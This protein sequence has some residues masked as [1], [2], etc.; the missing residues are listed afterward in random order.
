MTRIDGRR[1][2]DED[3][4][5]YE[6]ER[7]SYPLELV[8][9]II[10]YSGVD[11]ASRILEIGCGTGQA[12]RL[13]AQNGN[14]ILGL[15]PGP[16]L[17]DAARD[18]CRH[19][20]NVKIETV[21]FEDWQL[22]P[23]AFDL[24]ISATAFHWIKPEI[25]FPKCARAL[26]GDGSIGL[27]WNKHPGP[28]AAVFDEMNRHYQTHAPHMARSRAANE[29]DAFDQWISGYERTIVGTGL[30]RDVVS[31]AYPWTQTYDEVHYLGLLDTYS[32]HRSLPPPAKKLLYEAIADVIRRNGGMVTKEYVAVLF[33]AK[34]GTGV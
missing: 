16:N 13:F 30:F 32:D 31:K 10:S 23:E 33:M 11:R 17:A 8:G 25:G 28:Y 9:D 2:F 22:E 20:P 24:A 15:E 12:T 27:F 7:P 29:R 14:P 4:A 21:P 1:V 26:R 5:L 19:F 6:R 34:R 3:A 18:A